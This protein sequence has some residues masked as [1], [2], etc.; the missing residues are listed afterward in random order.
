MG[1]LQRF[2]RRL[3][4]LVEGAFAKVFKGDVQPVEIAGAL[5]R[6][7][8]DRKSVV[9]QDKVLVPNDFVVELGQHDYDRLQ[10]WAQPLGEELAA[11][12]REHATEQRYTFVGPVT[13]ALELMPDVDTGT[14]RVRSG[15]SAGD[16]V[17][18]GRLTVAG[19]GSSD[20]AA[21][22]TPRNALP[23]RPRLVVTTGGKALAGSPESRG[24]EQV[25]HLTHSVTVLGRA[26]DA[27]LKLN[28][29][30]VS[31]RHAEIRQ[32][33]GD[34]VVVD[35]GS[36]NGVR[37]NDASVTRQSLKTGD[38]VEIGSTTLVFRRDED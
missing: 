23:G 30:G 13:V 37:V 38:R 34:F 24:E 18:G 9:G 12:V 3:G 15:V 21:S 26:A 16:L 22:G 11:M 6:E 10:P 35:L 14:F 28:D 32:E 29:P 19:S 8:D 4:G 25:L 31:R 36:T 5:Q 1:V 20:V 33:G 27:D 7:T 17:E 2:E